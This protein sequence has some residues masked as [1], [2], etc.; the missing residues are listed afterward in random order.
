MDGIGGDVERREL[1]GRSLLRIAP[2]KASFLD[3]RLVL[4]VEEAAQV[5]RISRGLAYELVRRGDIPSI[6]LGRRVLVPVAALRE[7][8]SKGMS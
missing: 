2:D 6:R 3:R 5:L 7:L 4:S 8:L 1:D